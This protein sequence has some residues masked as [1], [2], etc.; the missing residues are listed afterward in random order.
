MSNDGAK[1]KASADGS[2]SAGWQALTIAAGAVVGT[3]SGFVLPPP[4]PEHVIA[5]FARFLVAAAI[6]LLA[7]V[8]ASRRPA[9]QWLVASLLLLAISVGAFAG[10]SVLRGTWLSKAGTHPPHDAE[11]MIV[12]TTLT[13]PLGTTAYAKAREFYKHPPSDAEIVSGAYDDRDRLW[14]AG[15][16]RF[17]ANTLMGLYVLLI[18]V[19]S[20]A[21]VSIVQYGASVQNAAKPPAA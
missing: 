9:K 17:R 7:G 21:A 11:L 1:A 14:D 20:T 10:Y 16:I 8:I 4:D 5:N 19:F 6:G 12:G 15:E 3:V 13:T 2:V 18:V